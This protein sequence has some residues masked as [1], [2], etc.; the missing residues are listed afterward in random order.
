MKNTIIAIIKYLFFLCLGFGLLGFLISNIG[1]S[2][3]ESHQLTGEHTFFDQIVIGWNKIK[4][5]LAHANYYWVSLALV[6]AITSHWFRALRWNLL[7]HPMGY[8]PRTLNTFLSVMVGYLANLAVPRMGEVSRCAALSKNEDIPTNKL[9]G[10]IIV[11]RGFDL[12]SLLALVVLMFLLQID[13]VGSFFAD[14]I[15]KNEIDFLSPINILKIIGILGVLIIGG[16][17]GPKLLLHLVKNSQHFFK[18]KR[19][20]VGLFQGLKS[21]K[22][23]ESKKMFLFHTLMI[24]TLYFLM[25]YLCFPSY[26]PTVDLSPLAGLS[27]LVIGSLGIVAPVQGGIGAYHW[28]VQKILVLYNINEDNGLTF[29]FIVHTAQTLLIILSGAVS[30]ILLPIFAKKINKND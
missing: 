7:I 17:F 25:V 1:E 6:A 5:D 24:W 4:A 18:I 12:F 23:L 2:H 8:K 27:T 16:W 10:T 30:L 21:F 13:I 28:C 11:E 19:L 14:I 29:A 15:S 3:I 22:K 9:I 20:L 26:L